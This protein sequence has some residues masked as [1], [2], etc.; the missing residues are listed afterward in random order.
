MLR[1]RRAS[2]VYT[3][4]S[5]GMI[6]TA[7][8][9]ETV[10]IHL[11]REQEEIVKRELAAGRFSSPEEVIAEALQSLAGNGGAK[12]RVS[13]GAQADAVRDMLEFAQTKSVQLGGLS[14]RDLIHEGHLL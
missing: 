7:K 12:T 10:D 13:N 11:T 3:L 5:A 2:C 9:G 6:R 4:A 8:K 14:I 1:L